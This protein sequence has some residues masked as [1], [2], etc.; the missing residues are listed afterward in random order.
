MGKS[1]RNTSDSDSDVSDDLSFERLSLRVAEFENA[2]CNPDKLL[3]HVFHENKNL[4][5][6]LED[7]FFEIASLRSVHNDMSAEPCD[8][9]MMIKV[10]YADLWLVHTK[11]ASHLQGAKLELRELKAHS[12]LLGACTSSL[13]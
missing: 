3:C 5:L 13:C 6:K 7:S 1:S 9:C 4:N 11:V 2:L 12:L 10:D 8:N